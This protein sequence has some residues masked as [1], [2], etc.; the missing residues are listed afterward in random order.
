MAEQG[1]TTMPRADGRIPFV[2][3]RQELLARAVFVFIAA[4]VTKDFFLTR[5]LHVTVPGLNTA[6]LVAFAAVAFS[7]GRMRPLWNRTH[8]LLLVSVVVF[9]C[10][11][12]IAV[13]NEY[14][15]LTGALYHTVQPAVIAALFFCIDLPSEKIRKILK[16]INVM[17]LLGTLGAFVDNAFF[18]RVARPPAL[19]LYGSWSFYAFPTY[20]TAWLSTNICG[21]LYLYRVTRRK[22]YLFSALFCMLAVVLAGRRKSFVSACLAFA[23]FMLL[24]NSWKKGLAK[25]V[26]CAGA[27]AAVLATAGRSFLLRFL[28]VKSYVGTTGTD[29]QA[30]T[31]LTLKCV[32]VARDYFP[33]GSGLGTFASEPAATHYSQLYYAY[34]LSNVFGLEP[35]AGQPGHPTFLLDTWWPHIV[36]EFG[37]LGTL[38]FLAL[39]FHPLTR[40]LRLPKTEERKNVLFFVFSVWCMILLESTGSTYPEQLQF[41]AVYCGLCPMLLRQAGKEA[42]Q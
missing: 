36:G 14:W 9:A 25:I 24:D 22:R 26:F 6:M 10:A 41:I 38:L 35:Y 15:R 31:A 7:L 39:W 33:W 27:G 37:F 8:L 40:V 28:A 19:F 29:T 11:N 34:G 42:E 17:I 13:G 3:D 21:T 32:D 4:L 12:T 2:L 16:W 23:A 30:R 5:L 20:Q 1:E 18:S